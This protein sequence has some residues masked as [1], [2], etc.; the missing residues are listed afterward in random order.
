MPEVSMPVGVVCEKR[1]ID[2][3]WVD[4]VWEPVAVL[5]DVPDVAPWTLLLREGPVER[6]YIGAADLTL[7]T[8]ETASYRDNLLAPPP[9]LWVV[10][11]EEGETPLNLVTVTAD[12]LEAEGHTETG[13]SIVGAVPMPPDIAGAIAAFVDEHHVERVFIKRQRKRHRDGAAET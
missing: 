3:K 8:T 7:A 11:R 5:S 9:R 4:H 2:H 1:R 12:P 10:V 13:T 6:Y